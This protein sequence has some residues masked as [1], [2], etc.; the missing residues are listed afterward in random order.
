VRP[1]HRHLLE[2]IS[3]NPGPEA[4]AW[5]AAAVARWWANGGDLEFHRCAGIGTPMKAINAIR[6]HLLRQA[7]EHID[8]SITHRAEVLAKLCRD[9]ENRL[10]PLWKSEAD[11]PSRAGPALAL[12]FRCKKMGADLPGS[13]RQVFDLITADAEIGQKHRTKS[14]I[15]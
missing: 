7:A 1:A 11:A 12:L 2:C 8:G 13:V 4:Q 5:A 3:G 6:N 15:R 14:P 10:W 9:M